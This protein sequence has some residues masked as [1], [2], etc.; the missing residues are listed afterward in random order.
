MNIF[1]KKENTD[2]WIPTTQHESA[3]LEIKKEEPQKEWIWVK[4][5]KGTEENLQCREFQYE[6]GK[7]F[8]H[9]KDDVV[10]CKSGFHICTKL[11]DVFNYYELNGINRFFVAEALVEKISYEKAEGSKGLYMS[12]Y[13]GWVGEDSKVTAKEIR[14]VQ[15]CS[16][17]DLKSFVSEKYPLVETAEEYNKIKEYADFAKNKF[18]SILKSLGFT[19]I[20]AILLRENSNNVTT[21]AKLTKM[22]KALVSEK[23]SKDIQIFMLTNLSNQKG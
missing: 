19:E 12:S 2:A 23:V 22:A 18:V 20:F 1:K 3:P 4:G 16:F 21:Y 17:E 5:Y 14:L 11:K 7:I 13:R 8:V 10:L 9:D 15:E 6:V